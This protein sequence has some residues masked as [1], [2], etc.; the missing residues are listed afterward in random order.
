MRRLLIK[1]WYLL[2]C[3]LALEVAGYG[4][5]WWLA[6]YSRRAA[7]I[8]FNTAA[9]AWQPVKNVPYA[10]LINRH[11]RAAGVSAQVVACVIQAES[12]FQPRAVSR[13]G[14]YGLMQIIPD[15]WRQVN[16]RIKA[17]AGRHEGDCT[18][19]CFFDPELNIRVGTAYLAELA[20]RYPGR[21][22]LALAAYNA[23]PGAVD[24]YGGVPPYA[25]TQQY[26]ARIIHYWH[27]MQ[28]PAMPVQAAGAAWER[29][30]RALGWL[31][32]LTLFMLPVLARFLH[33]L[34]RSWRWR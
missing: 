24:Y 14:A 3:F 27:Q 20:G 7:A 4:L 9:A 19:E 6:D 25:E 26:V 17:C 13:A 32:A 8:R 30:R 31:L 23:G 18:R 15:T 28:S 10:D 5:A 1:L 33:K 29:A 2:L 12:S 16:G 34:H 22:D 21:L 11:S